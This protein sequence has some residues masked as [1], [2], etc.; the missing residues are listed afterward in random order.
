MEYKTNSEL[1]VE[2]TV[3]VCAHTHS[4]MD[5]FQFIGRTLKF[6]CTGGKQG[7]THFVITFILPAI[8]LQMFVS[9]SEFRECVMHASCPVSAAGLW[10]TTWFSGFN[11][12]SS[13]IFLDSFVCGHTSPRAKREE[14]CTHWPPAPH[15]K[16]FLSDV[17]YFFIRSQGKLP[18]RGCILVFSRASIPQMKTRTSQKLVRLSCG[19]DAASEVVRGRREKPRQLK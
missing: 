3:E 1:D 13:F 11:F 8:I 17:I 7:G 14:W 15:L 5:S 19:P 10:V 9:A 12:F 18:K 4:S 6:R 16:V 2:K